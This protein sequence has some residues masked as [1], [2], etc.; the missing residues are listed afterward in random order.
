MDCQNWEPVVF[1]SKSKPSVKHTQG[2]SSLSKIEKSD[3]PI[4]PKLLSPESI[5]FIVSFR[6]NNNLTQKMLDQRCCF[7][8]NTINNLEARRIGPTPNQL[9]ILNQALKTGLTLGI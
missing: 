5:Q 3:I 4:A 6:K 2:N 8:A 1:N 7:P 9:R